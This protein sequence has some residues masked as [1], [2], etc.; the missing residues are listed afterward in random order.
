MLACVYVAID[1]NDSVKVVEAS[2]LW[3]RPIPW[4]RPFDIWALLMSSPRSSQRDQEKLSINFPNKSL[5]TQH[6]SS[7]FFVI[8]LI[9]LLD[10]DFNPPIA[11]ASL[12]FIASFATVI[13]QSSTGRSQDLLHIAFSIITASIHHDWTSECYPDLKHRLFF[14]R[15]CLLIVV[16]EVHLTVDQ[17]D[18]PQF[19]LPCY[20]VEISHSWALFVQMLL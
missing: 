7:V 18:N 4:Y 3:L 1:Q 8:Q 11:Q 6:F 13:A 9:P 15:C 14:S 5:L 12:S 17:V 20:A 19:W 10:L 16:S 2:Y